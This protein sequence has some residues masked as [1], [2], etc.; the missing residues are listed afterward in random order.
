MELNWDKTVQMQIL[1]S[2]SVTRPT[3]EPIKIVSQVIYLGGL[4]TNDGR[5]GHELNRRL[6]EGNAIF[7]E[8][9]KVWNHSSIGRTRKQ[10]IYI[11]CVISKLLYSLESLWLLKHDKQRLDAFH[12]K[13]LRKILGIPHSYYSRVSNATVLE[14]AGSMPLSDM[15]RDRQAQ[16]YRKIVAQDNHS[17]V[18]C[19]VCDEGGAPKNWAEHRRRGRPRQQWAQYVYKAQEEL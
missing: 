4:I 2:S 10:H 3:G 6:G 5:V 17:L 12:C 8:L 7:Q 1:T 19:L 11:S 13:C 15:L 9:C 18:K 16:A 14:R